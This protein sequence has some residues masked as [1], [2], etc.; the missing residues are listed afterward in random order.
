MK[1]FLA[2][3]FLLMCAVCHA[4]MPPMIHGDTVVIGGPPTAGAPQGGA[5]VNQ[6]FT[7]TIT[8]SAGRDANSTTA[9]QATVTPT[10][11]GTADKLEVY[12]N[13]FSGSVNVVLGLYQGT[14]LLGT[15]T[16]VASSGTG[17][18]VGTLSSGVSITANTTYS[19]AYLESAST[20]NTQFA[21]DS[22]AAS[23]ADNGLTYPTLPN[24]FV[25]VFTTQANTFAGIHLQ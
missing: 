22:T 14:T 25:D 8:V 21:I 4:Q 5:S 2:I 7:N 24:P 23:N 9:W 17:F 3:W 13:V 15:C 10:Q 11:S 18:L 20:A 19:V 12:V 1:Y 6:W 16:P